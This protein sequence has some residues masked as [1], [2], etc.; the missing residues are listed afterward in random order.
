MAG[1]AWSREDDT[2]AIKEWNEGIPASVIAIKLGRTRSSVM[3]RLRLLNLLGHNRGKD[4]VRSEPRERKTKHDFTHHLVEPW[5]EFTARKQA[6]RRAAKLAQ[7]QA[8]KASS[9]NDLN[10]SVSPDKR[11]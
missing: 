7:E 11:K 6:E 4:P 8:A 3:S 2:L 5:A 1:K 9:Y 10:A